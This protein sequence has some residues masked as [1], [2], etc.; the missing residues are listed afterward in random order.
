MALPKIAPKEYLKLE[1][2]GGQL[3]LLAEKAH[4]DELVPLFKQR[5]LECESSGPVSAT[6]ERLVF[7]EGAA[8][9]QAAEILAA[10]RGAKGS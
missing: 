10:Y 9:E 4:A 1:R 6:H 3:Q 5:G 8:E 2:R 7:A